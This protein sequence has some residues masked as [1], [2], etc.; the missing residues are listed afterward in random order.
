MVLN[1]KTQKYKTQ[2]RTQ[3]FM[4]QKYMYGNKTQK[5]KVR[6]RKAQKPS[7]KTR[8]EKTNMR[9]KYDGRRVSKSRAWK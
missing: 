2:N 5:C 7:P 6:D 4:V 1:H 9:F 8:I 3:K